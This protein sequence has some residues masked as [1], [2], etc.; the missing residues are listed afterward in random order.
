MGTSTIAK[1]ELALAYHKVQLVN[2]TF[3]LAKSNAAW[4]TTFSN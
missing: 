1:P 4:G 3:A 2:A